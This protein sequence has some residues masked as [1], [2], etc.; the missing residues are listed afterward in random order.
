MRI[1]LWETI[2]VFIFMGLPACGICV[3]TSL[4]WLPG[5]R[6]YIRF[7]AFSIR[8][9]TKCKD[10]LFSSLY[11]S[12]CHV[13]CGVHIAAL[14]LPIT[15]FGWHI[16]HGAFG[17]IKANELS[18]CRGRMHGFSQKRRINK[19]K[20]KKLFGNRVSLLLFCFERAIYTICCWF[21]K[22]WRKKCDDRLSCMCVCYLSISL[23]VFQLPFLPPK[24]IYSSK[25]NPR[26]RQT[27]SSQTP[28]QR[29]RNKSNESNHIKEQ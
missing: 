28:P 10:I 6:A 7:D 3:V 1:R 18:R 4:M 27:Y 17:D 29:S 20:P 13:T 12:T 25:L 8:K 19:N 16:Q 14:I 15:G 26:H 22:I 24:F 9:H 2:S 5:A 11:L 23:P 21:I